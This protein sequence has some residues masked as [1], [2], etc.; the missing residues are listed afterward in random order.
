MSLLYRFTPDELRLILI[1]PKQVEM[2]VYNSIPHL[3]V[4][5]VTDPKKVMLA[6]RW[7]INEMEKRYKILAKVGVRNITGFNARARNAA[8][9]PESP[10][11]E[12]LEVHADEEEDGDESAETPAAPIRVPRE[13]DLIIPDKLPYIVVIVDELADLMQTA[14]ADVESAVARLTAKARAAGIHLIV[15]TQTPRREVVT[16]VIKTNIPAR[17]AFQVP[18]GLDSRVILDENGAENLLGKG[19]LLYRPP[20]VAGYTRGQGAF[21]SDQE[22]QDVVDFVG[23]QGEAQFAPELDAKL[24]GR[25]PAEIEVTEEDK[26]L[27]YEC[28]DVIRQERKASTSNLQRRLRLGYNRAAYV[29]DYLERIGVL[30]P[31]DGAKPREILVDLETYMLEL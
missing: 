18:S 21:V 27:I 10:Q 26:K 24:S 11:L 5:V 8:P 17:I 3:V 7:V 22:V 19:D 30:G 25:A 16:G 23:G 1:D 12:F 9:P 20:G 29:I 31:P 6:L 14:P 28:F 2:Q 4:P 15:A 13:D